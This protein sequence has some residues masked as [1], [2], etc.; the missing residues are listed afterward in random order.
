[1]IFAAETERRKLLRLREERQGF[2]RE[3]LHYT[4]HFSSQHI[5]ALLLLSTLFA[6]CFKT[7][8]FDDGIM[9]PTIWTKSPR[10][11]MELAGIYV[12]MYLRQLGM[13][14]CIVFYAFAPV[15]LLHIVML[16]RDLIWNHITYALTDA[17][18]PSVPL[19]W[20]DRKDH[21]LFPARLFICNGEPALMPYITPI[22]KFRSY[23]THSRIQEPQTIC[24]ICLD[25]L[26]YSDVVD[27]V[28]MTSCGHLFHR[29]CLF[30]QWKSA[31]PEFSPP[32]GMPCA[33]CRSE[34]D[35]YH[36][37]WLYDEYYVE[38]NQWLIW[39]CKITLT[40]LHITL[41]NYVNLWMD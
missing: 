2:L 21:G 37:S 39:L 20:Y 36:Y 38:R 40:K 9:I 3:K 27:P 31:N 26:N 14:G 24:P 1:M 6:S 30:Q 35:Y 23:M 28:L 13:V 15:I 29:G 11:I 33:V 4:Q 19:S 16:S 7:W 12:G 18:F 5:M 25:E 41:V 32:V 22:L 10:I 34:N 8:S 17:T